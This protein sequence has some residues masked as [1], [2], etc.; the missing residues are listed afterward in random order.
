MATSHSNSFTLQVIMPLPKPS[1]MWNTDIGVLSAS[2]NDTNPLFEP[3]G[4]P[5]HTQL[6]SEADLNL[7]KKNQSALL[8]ST[9]KDWNRIHKENETVSKHLYHISLRK[10]NSE[11]YNNVASCMDA[12]G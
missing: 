7:F 6:V 5:T 2:L 12:F 8:A 3:S 9:F 10:D 4:S 1:Q 11:Y